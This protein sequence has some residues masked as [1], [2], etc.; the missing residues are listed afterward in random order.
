MYI[1]VVVVFSSDLGILE[2]FNIRI[3]G[4]Y[5]RTNSKTMLAALPEKLTVESVQS[6]LQGCLPSSALL[7]RLSAVFKSQRYLQ[8]CPPRAVF[9][10][11]QRHPDY[12]GISV[13]HYLSVYTCGVC[14]KLC[15]LYDCAIAVEHKSMLVW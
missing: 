10:K 6:N 12:S 5:I 7:T 3:L 4:R 14:V 9:Y 1:N 15:Q 8:G 13:S 11:S 2:Y